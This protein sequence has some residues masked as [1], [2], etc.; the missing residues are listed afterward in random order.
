MPR[1]CGKLSGRNYLAIALLAAGLGGC[2]QDMHNQPKYRPL[3][4]SE[5]FP[6][7]RSAR[8]LPAGVIAR[9]H[10]NDG[11]SFHT[12]TANGGFL[13]QIPVTVDLN[14]L[15]R[16]QQRFNIYCA[17]CHGRVGDGRGMIA[18]RGFMIPSDLNS[19]RV[20][21]APPG[22]IFAVI[23]NGYGAMPDYGDQVDVADRWAIVAYVRALE[24]SRQGTLADVPA[25]AQAQ[26]QGTP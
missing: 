3:R 20:R 13:T 15:T 10:L 24:R 5:F 23:S 14:L 7:G 11:D 19:P 1:E 26:L 9:G 17:P 4:A 25:D 6:D 16:G 12:G 2:R 22:Y 8:P 21:Q 18:R